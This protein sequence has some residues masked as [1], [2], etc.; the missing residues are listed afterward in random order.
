MSFS[1]KSELK[2]SFKKKQLSAS[3]LNIHFDYGQDEEATADET[4]NLL[5]AK[6]SLSAVP[7]EPKS[8]DLA[9][10]MHTVNTGLNDELESSFIDK[11][12]RSGNKQAFKLKHNFVLLIEKLKNNSIMAHWS[13]IKMF[14]LLFYSLGMIVIFSICA[15]RVD[16]WSQL[17]IERTKPTQLLFQNSA[18]SNLRSAYFRLS[19]QGPFIDINDHTNYNFI[20]KTFVKINVYDRN[21]TDLSSWTLIVKEA[22]EHSKAYPSLLLE[23]DFELDTK[24]NKNEVIFEVSTNH[25]EPL[26]LSYDCKQL[27]QNFKYRIVYAM[28]LLIFVYGLIIFELIHRTLAAGISIFVKLLIV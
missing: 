14:I 28:V 10:E 13:N 5:N 18:N 8:D 27:S 1:R 9:S 2:I 19:L 15:E 3:S 25:R 24:F 26:S 4:S 12:N 21:G 17:V 16:L 6:R 7:K 22:I 23:H 11:F 20:N